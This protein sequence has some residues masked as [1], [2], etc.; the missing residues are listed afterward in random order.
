MNPTKKNRPVTGRLFQ[1]VLCR[2]GL[3]LACFEPAL[4]LVDDVYAAFTAHNAAI[5]VPVFQRTE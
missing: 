3:A 5:A 2:L 4:R 1:V